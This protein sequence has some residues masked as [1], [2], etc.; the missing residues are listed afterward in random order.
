MKKINIKELEKLRTQKEIACQNYE[1][2][3]ARY[4]KCIR[5]NFPQYDDDRYHLESHSG[6]ETFIVDE[7][8]GSEIYYLP[9]GFKL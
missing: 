6:G 9:N 3:E 7:T 2:K 1:A 8:N 5:A 4:W